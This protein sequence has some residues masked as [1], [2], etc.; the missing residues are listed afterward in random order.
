MPNPGYH[1]AARGLQGA[2]EYTRAHKVVEDGLKFFGGAARAP[3]ARRQRHRGRPPPVSRSLRLAAPP[4]PPS[5]DNEDL[6]KLE[7][8]LR[9]QAER[10]ERERRSGM[11]PI[12]LVRQPFAP[13]PAPPRT[14]EAGPRVGGDLAAAAG[15][16]SS[17]RRATIGSRRRTS[18]T[19]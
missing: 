15:A 19:R 5:P 10:Q 2:G 18:R 4:W 11:S 3:R 1:R 7:A 9:P 8:E 14:D 12:E 6:R 13:V 16:R 17:R